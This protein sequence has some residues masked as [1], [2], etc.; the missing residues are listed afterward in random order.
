MG[1]AKSSAVRL[2]T[3]Q[4]FI[5]FDSL[6]VSV[7]SGMPT[8]EEQ[9]AKDAAELACLGG[10]GKEVAVISQAPFMRGGYLGGS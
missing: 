7:H 6:D 4:R 8:Q 1:T 9:H 3:Y 5:E 2:P 10:G